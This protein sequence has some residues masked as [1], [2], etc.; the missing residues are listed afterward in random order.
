MGGIPEG[1]SKPTLASQGWATR[2]T[3]GSKNGRGVF[4]GSL[5]KILQGRR[6]DIIH[7]PI[8][9]FAESGRIVVFPERVNRPL[10]SLH[11]IKPFNFVS[12]E[13][14]TIDHVR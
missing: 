11:D 9:L 5:G 6:P 2:P 10:P 4:C 14:P 3:H 1:T 12:Y 8:E 13:Q 7:N